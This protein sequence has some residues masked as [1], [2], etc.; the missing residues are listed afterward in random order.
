MR[1]AKRDLMV[2]FSVLVQALL[3]VV[4]E[5]S[6]LYGIAKD[7]PV[8]FEESELMSIFVCDQN[9]FRHLMVNISESTSERYF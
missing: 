3:L 6:C 9:F 1:K 4:S 5:F 2:F 8:M 7:R